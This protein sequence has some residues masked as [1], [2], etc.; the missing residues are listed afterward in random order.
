MNTDFYRNIIQNANVGIAFHRIV[1]DAAGNPID[2][3]WVETN[4][5]YEKFTGL[6]DIIHKKTGDL[7]PTMPLNRA[8]L[9]RIYGEIAL[10]GGRKNIE[11]YFEPSETWFEIQIT[12]PEKYYFT[13]I[14][15]DCTRRKKL[16][17]G[18]KTES[19]FWNEV[20]V[21]IPGMFFMLR[22]EGQFILWNRNL[23]YHLDATEEQIP[24]LNFMSFFSKQERQRI[25][26]MFEMV[27]IQGSSDIEAEMISLAG[28]STQFFFSCH[29]ITLLSIDYIIGSGF[30][31]SQRKASEIATQQAKKAAE[32]ANRAKSEFLANMSHEIRTPM[33]A[34]IGLSHLA[35]QT[36]ITAQQRNY[37]EKIYFSANSLLRVLNDILDFAKIEAGK[38]NM[39]EHNFTLDEV[40]QNLISVINV[41]IVEKRLVFTI[42]TSPAIPK[43]LRGD[44][45]RLGQVLTNLVSNAVKFTQQGEILIKI[46]LIEDSEETVILRFA[47]YDTGLGMTPEQVK[48]LFQ[49]FYQAD[50]SITRQYGGTGLGLSISKQLIKMMGG[51]IHVTSQLGVGSC[52]TFTARFAKSK[53]KGDLSYEVVTAEQVFQKLS[54]VR[55]LLVEDNEINQQVAREIL[56][57]VGVRVTVANNGQESVAMVGREQFDVILMDMQMPVMDG[58]TASLEIR[59]R[60]TFFDL[61]IL[62]MTAN[63]MTGD[64]EKCL[65]AG[66]N[67]HIAK[68]INTA[69]LY[70]TLIRW[71]RPNSP[72]P[73]TVPLVVDSPVL[74]INDHLAKLMDG[75]ELS[76]VLL[77][78][79]PPKKIS[80][81][82][83]PIIPLST[84]CH[85]FELPGFDLISAVKRLM[86][87]WSLLRV[88]LLRFRSDFSDASEKLEHYIATGARSDGIRLI[89]TIKGLGKSIG[90]TEL[91][92]L[93]E[94]L[95]KELQIDQETP[96]APFKAE[97]QAVLE[98]ISTLS[99]PPSPMI[100][101]HSSLDSTEVGQ[102][103][104]K[105]ATLLEDSTLIP[106]ELLE[107]LRAQLTGHVETTVLDKLIAQVELFAFMDAKPT[108]E[109]IA[110]DLG[111]NLN[112][113]FRNC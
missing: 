104:Q 25:L 52:F 59:K 19:T 87:N 10:N 72:L 64:R 27:F 43:H 101:A 48:N 113:S 73:S 102:L 39:E 111:L 18:L 95:E 36:S 98:S 112:E 6:S 70:E 26:D 37:L 29:R 33:N 65:A 53:D 60:F 4:P 91:A 34:V 3:E 85:A 42:E 14:L 61:P 12:S 78:W 109:K 22:K 17:A 83:Q 35:L 51:E 66:M 97:L 94:R 92:L 54:D 110:E 30:D 81:S 103:L 40:L 15:T 99:V 63:A 93:A 1:T 31:I 11:V 89:H 90:A 69:K 23:S 108:L 88:L 24:S 41:K 96:R 50:T 58:L 49:A 107:K 77:K 46:A 47:I 7:P 68:P 44:S 45:L 82:P 106:D 75:Q 62:A 21:R 5:C 8:A 100:N 84:D 67:D 2:Y 86:G 28:N 16:E 71:V 55:V 105:L 20:F 76:T 13:T 74:D 9:L 79:I 80:S 56:E 57:K 32:S 38:L